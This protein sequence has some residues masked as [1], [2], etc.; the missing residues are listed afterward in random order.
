MEPLTITAGSF[1]AL[2]VLDE[3][4]AKNKKLKKY[5]GSLSWLAQLV[6]FVITKRIGG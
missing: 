6:R 3:I 5:K 2:K 1:F 4:L